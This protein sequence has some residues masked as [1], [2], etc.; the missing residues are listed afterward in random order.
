MCFVNDEC[1]WH[2]TVVEKFISIGEEPTQ[3]MEC[4]RDFSVGTTFH[5][6]YM[7][8]DDE[9]G[10]C[11]DGDCECPDG[12]CECPD[13][14]CCSCDEPDYGMTFDY[15]RCDDCEKYLD[16]VEKAELAAG[17]GRDEARPP[18]EMMIEYIRNGG[19]S[20]AKKYFIEAVKRYPELKTSGYLA[21]LW[22]RMFA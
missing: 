14:D 15:K 4:R 20:E 6:T 8:E 18:Y 13:E 5:C 17:C 7:Q 9:C 12:D 16:A 11:R 22:W 1:E 2:A 10:A 3:C 19:V 21:F